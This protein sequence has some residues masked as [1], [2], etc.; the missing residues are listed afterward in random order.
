MGTVRKQSRARSLAAVLAACALLSTG[1]SSGGEHLVFKIVIGFSNRGTATTTDLV[2]IAMS[3][4]INQTDQTV[5]LRRVSLVSAPKS[6]HLRRL[7]ATC[8]SMAGQCSHSPSAI[9]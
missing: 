1:C 7:P 9:T 3:D 8:P 2:D 5:T 4:L 6:V